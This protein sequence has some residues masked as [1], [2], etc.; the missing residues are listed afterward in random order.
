MTGPTKSH[1]SHNERIGKT[2]LRSGLGAKRIK[3]AILDSE[4]LEIDAAFCWQALYSRDARFDGRFFVGTVTTGIYCRSTCPISCGHPTHIRWFRSAAAADAAGFRPCKRCRPD[5]SPGSSA[6]FGTW[7][8]VSHSLKLISQGALDEGNLEQ[9]AERVGIGSRHLRRLFDQHLGASPLKIARLHRV[10]VAK[11]L[12]TETDLPITEIA[13]STGFRSIRQFNH[14]VQTTFRQ[15][16]TELRRLHGTSE[17]SVSERGIV[18]ELPYRSPFSWASMIQFLGARATPGVEIIEDGFY[19]RTIEID[20]TAGAIEVWDEPEHDRLLMRVILPKYDG[21]MQVVRR[22]RRL[23]DL[24]AD[25]VHIGH[26]LGQ[27]PRLSKM[28]AERSGLRMPGAWDGFELAVRAILGQQLTAVD[29]PTL[30]GRL[31][32]GFGKPV[33]VPIRGLSYLFPQPKILAEGNLR[34]I[35]VPQAQAKTIRSLAHALSVG[36]FSFD[37]S[38]GLEDTLARLRTIPGLDERAVCYIAMRSFGEP[39]ALPYTENGL[40]QAVATDNRSISP[41]ELLRTFETFRPWR[42]YAAMHF[43]AA[44]TKPFG[45]TSPVNSRSALDRRRGPGVK[46]KRRRS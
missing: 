17:G 42:A 41:T 30:A 37:S 1:V 15:S 8:V 3:G 13:F 29:A 18:I 4:D 46:Q 28:L 9:L 11:S 2:S 6:W 25:A 31:V 12:I 40:R 39:D 21:L 14:S 23:F 22:S 7:A 5:T 36:S 35:G 32:Q 19:R 20:D 33:D 24:G 43:A 45:F 26:H 38:K 10:N 34:A 27:Y 44:M 16:P